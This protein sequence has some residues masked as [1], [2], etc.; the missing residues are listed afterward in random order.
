MSMVVDKTED[1]SKFLL[2]VDS[3]H[4]MI[5]ADIL[6]KNEKVQL[7]KGEEVTPHFS[8]EPFCWS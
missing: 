5:E 6:T 8:D 2:S 3:F 4:R 7:I 1:V